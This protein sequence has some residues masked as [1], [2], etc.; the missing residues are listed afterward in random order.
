M[1]TEAAR[2][3]RWQRRDA[4]GAGWRLSRAGRWALPL[5]AIGLAGCAQLGYLVQSVHGHLEL[6]GQAR[7]VTQWLADPQ[8][9]AGLRERLTLA[10]R[11]RRFAVDE[12][13]LPEGPSYRRFAALDRRA[14][15]WNV[16]AA[17]AL[18]LSLHTW[19]VPVAGCVGYRGYF[20]LAAAQRQARLLRAQ[21]LDVHVYPVPAYSTLGRTDWLGGDPLL[22]TFIDWPEGELARLLFHE[23]AHQRVY[24]PNDTA[25]N[26][27]YATAVER[28]GVQRWLARA[29]ARVR[30]EFE[31]AE[32]RRRDFRALVATARRALQTVY[33]SAEPQATKRRRKAEILAQLRDDHRQL[34]DGKWSGHPGFDLWFEQVNN[35]ALGVQAAYHAGVPAFERLFEAEG[36]DFERFHAQVQAWAARSLAQRQAFLDMEGG[37]PLRKT[38][39]HPPFSCAPSGG[40]DGHRPDLGGFQK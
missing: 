24:V 4:D 34:R 6:V 1:S 40:R 2:P 3:H 20:D 29:D 18:S 23:M 8:T 31:S 12:L 13:A 5:V 7:P 14:A 37:P 10:E 28:L 25:F 33:D 35:A 16:V 19:C 15:V 22:N 32:A 21:G 9:P 26:E 17:P 38:S 36:C 11:L 30:A 27:S 39:D